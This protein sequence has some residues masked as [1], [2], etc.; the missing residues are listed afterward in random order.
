MFRIRKYH[1]WKWAEKYVNCLIMSDLKK[2]SLFSLEPLGYSPV[3]LSRS[4]HCY[5]LACIL[6]I[7]FLCFSINKYDHIE[8][9]MYL[10]VCG[11]VHFWNPNE[12]LKNMCFSFSSN[13][14]WRSFPRGTY[15]ATLF[16]LMSPEYSIA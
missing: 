15:G 16:F 6:S 13:R 10:C 8:I 4:Y 9:Y 3:G 2:K 1:D 14:S 7:L 11:F 5:H 12:F